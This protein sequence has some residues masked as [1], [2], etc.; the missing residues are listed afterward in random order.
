M[1]ILLGGAG[2]NPEPSK[3]PY[4]RRNTKYIKRSRPTYISIEK[5]RR[6]ETNMRADIPPR[7]VLA[8]N[9][10]ETGKAI[11]VPK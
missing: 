4:Y 8:H 5:Y 7:K 2:D 6:T 10:P 11:I 9:Q 1:L 3:G